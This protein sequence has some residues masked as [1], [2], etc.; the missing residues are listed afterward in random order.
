MLR[1]ARF[2]VTPGVSSNERTVKVAIGLN[3]LTTPR[4]VLWISA[5]STKQLFAGYTITTIDERSQVCARP[6]RNHV[7]QI[8]SNGAE[9]LAFARSSIAHRLPI[10]GSDCASALKI[11]IGIK[12]TRRS[13]T[14]IAGPSYIAFTLAGFVITSTVSTLS[15]VNGRE[16]RTSGRRAIHTAIPRLALADTTVLSR[17]QILAIGGRV[18]GTR[19]VATDLGRP[20]SDRA[21]GDV[22]GWAAKVFIALADI[23]SRGRTCLVVSSCRLDTSTNTKRW[24]GFDG[25]V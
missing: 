25:T 1:H 6:T 3:R 24:Q 9:T 12:R 16:V 17:L 22:A 2:V 4:P 20:S 15:S 11:R 21:H 18:D 23:G 5:C 13:V 7:V 19:S 14:C 8:Q 10:V